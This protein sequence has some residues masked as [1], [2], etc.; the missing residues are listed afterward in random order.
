[1]NINANFKFFW[2]FVLVTLIIFIRASNAFVYPILH[3][4]DGWHLLAYYLEH[5]DPRDI[6]RFYNGYLS[7]LPNIASYFASFAS[8]STTPYFMAMYALFIGAVAHTVFYL[9]RFRRM[10]PNDHLRAFICL[11]IVIM[12]LGNQALFSSTAYSLWHLLLALL[13]LA[14][15]SPVTDEQHRLVWWS[16]IP[17]FIFLALAI[18]SHPLS[19]LALPLF[20]YNLVTQKGWQA[21]LFCAALIVITF[22]Y[23][24]VGV[25]PGDTR[26]HGQISIMEL[27]TSLRLIAERVVFEALFGNPLRVTA[28]QLGYA[29]WIYVIVGLLTF[30]LIIIGVLNRRYYDKRDVA[31]LVVIILFILGFTLMSVVVRDFLSEVQIEPWEQRYFYLQQKFFLIAFVIVI[32]LAIKQYKWMQRVGM[33]MALSIGLLLNI[34][35]YVYKYPSFYTV[36]EIG[37][38]AKQDLRHF[39]TLTDEQKRQDFLIFWHQ[40]YKQRGC[41]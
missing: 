26:F 15:V 24:V 32:Y 2:L 27:L 22:S 23:L 21:K 5:D 39:E 6:W 8:P 9:K 10:V 31:H 18:Y 1:M 20:F 35:N 34:H 16:E 40:L 30:I 38:Q 4:E 33:I 19:F 12:P 3:C 41:F 7:L 13:L 25:S 37:K 28:L 29:S 14:Y 11:F 36:A 17:L